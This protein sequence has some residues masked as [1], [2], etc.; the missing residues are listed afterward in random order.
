MAES[1]QPNGFSTTF[2]FGLNLAV[3]IEAAAALMKEAL[4]KIGI[5]VTIQK[6][7]DA[8]LTM[9][10]AGM[11]DIRPLQALTKYERALKETE[12]YFKNIPARGDL[13]IAAF[14]SFL[15]RDIG[16]HPEM[17]VFQRE[18]GILLANEIH[19]SCAENDE[20]LAAERE[21]RDPHHPK[22]AMGLQRAG[23]APIDKQ[24]GFPARQPSDGVC[25]QRLKHTLPSRGLIDA[26]RTIDISIGAAG[27]CL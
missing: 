9:R 8:Q 17:V 25:I 11:K 4:A 22:P 24:D 21:V 19:I 18:Q 16:A 20:D 5:D 7:P 3:I 10:C 6:T 12:T 2:S 15:S 13:T 27:P 26:D 14:L 23:I 1:S